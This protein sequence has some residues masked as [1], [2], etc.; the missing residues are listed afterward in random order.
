MWTNTLALPRLSFL[1]RW[2]DFVWPLSDLWYFLI[3]ILKTP[4][5]VSL[6]LPETSGCLECREK[7]H[8]KWLLMFDITSLTCSVTRQVPLMHLLFSTTRLSHEAALPRENASMSQCF[9]QIL[10][11]VDP[12]FIKNVTAK[13]GAPSP[14]LLDPPMIA[15]TL[16]MVT[17]NRTWSSERSRR[18]DRRV[19]SSTEKTRRGVSVNR[20]SVILTTLFL[21]CCVGLK[22][23]VAETRLSVHCMRRYIFPLWRHNGSMTSQPLRTCR[24]ERVTIYY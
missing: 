19:Y 17:G 18:C 10:P 6:N 7:I 23:A 16:I 20:D 1:G 24:V 22:S 21:Y 2:N 14:I 4:S 3:S 11:V 12:E 9:R 13:R 15:A 5:F 8:S